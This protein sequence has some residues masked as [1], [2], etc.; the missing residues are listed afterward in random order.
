MTSLPPLS[1]DAFLR[2][3]IALARLRGWLVAHFRP[4]RVQRR[5]GTCY[6]ETPVQADGAGWP[7]LVLVR[8]GRVLFAELKRQAGR[9]EPR[10]RAWLDALAA[11]GL[12]VAV[13]RPS[14]WAAI[15]TALE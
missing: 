3:V 7:D 14:D 6:H 1:E 2:Q 11:A 5:D 12:S 13:W 15:E 10:Q 9:V 8:Q 4:V